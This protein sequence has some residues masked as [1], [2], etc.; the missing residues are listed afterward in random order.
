MLKYL[1]T[2]WVTFSLIAGSALYSWGAGVGDAAPEF[3]LKT[4]DEKP[5]SLADF[6]GKQPVMLVFWATWCPICREELPQVKKIAEQFG[7]KGLSV[8]G[9]NVGVNDSPRRAKAYRDK[10][11]IDY[12]LAFDEGSEVTRAFGVAGTPTVLILDK[13]GIIRYR[14]AAVPKDLED[15][16]AM[17][18]E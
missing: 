7:P 18:M 9:V 13:Q 6:K 12:P 14:D 16:F 5:L 10:Y 3:S 4:L 8:V 17:L 15:H 11:G 1:K 2:F